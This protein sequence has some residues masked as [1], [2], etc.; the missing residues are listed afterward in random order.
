MQQTNLSLDHQ[1]AMACELGWMGPGRDRQAVG[2]FWRV[3]LVDL[4]MAYMKSK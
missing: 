3:F 4:E 2:K 1:K